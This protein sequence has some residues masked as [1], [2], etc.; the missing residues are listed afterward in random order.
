[1]TK[2]TTPEFGWLSSLP[3]LSARQRREVASAFRRALVES[4]LPVALTS[5][6][7][8]TI[9]GC[10]QQFEEMLGVDEAS[11]H[12]RR[13]EDLVHP[14]DRR[15]TS[16]VIRRLR[17]GRSKLER[18]EAR[19]IRPDGRVVWTR[20]SVLRVDGPAEVGG[21]YLVAVVEDQT[22]L[23]QSQE[24]SSALV[25]IGTRIAA[26]ASLDETVQRLT[27]LAEVRWSRS[28]CLLTVLDPENN[29]LSA[30]CPANGS[31]F[32]SELPALPVGPA[33]G[34]CGTAAWRDEPSAVPNLL[35]DPSVEKLRPIFARNGVV[36]SWAVPLHDAEGHVIGTL[37]V[38]HSYPFSPTEED[39]AAAASVAGVAAIAVIAERRRQSATREQ[40]RVRTDPRTGL[41]NDV[42]LMEHIEAMLAGEHPVSVAVAT[43]RGPGRL[44]SLESMARTAL[45]T[46]AARGRALGQVPEVAATG[47][48]TVA[49]LARAEWGEREARLLH[50]VLTR[51]I[52]VGTAVIRPEV[53]VGIAVSTVTG[54]ETAAELLA[55]ATLAVP[56]R[57]G[58]RLAEPEAPDATSDHGLVTEIT[59]AFR[60][61]EFVPYYQPQFDL[62]TGAAVGSEALA[63][64]QHPVR[65]VLGPSSF[66]S[67]VDS[68]GASTEL[69]FAMLRRVAAEHARRIDL[70][71]AGH[72]AV[73][74][75]A[76]DLLNESLLQVLRD[77]ERQLWRQ[78]SLELTEAQFVRPDA[79]TAVE[80]LAALGYA[81]ALDDF[82]TGYS[83]LSAI[84]T[85]PVSVVKIDQS[86]VAR[87]Q[88]DA[89]AEA[90]IAA[91]TALCEQLAIT[92]VAEG[93]ET[94][95][96]A[97]AVRDLGCRIGQGFLFGSPQPIEALVPEGLSRHDEAARARRHP[98]PLGEAAR[99]RLQELDVQGASPA[100]I[101]AALNRSG[102][103][104][105][106]GTRWHARSVR[107]FLDE[108]RR[109]DRRR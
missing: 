50:R 63:R 53:A 104:A 70:G 36:S 55:R 49:F 62:V 2:A 1:M 52:D 90:L 43:L 7:D 21:A 44:A 98:Q 58:S 32:L 18:Y 81:I 8:G 101:A 73:N 89:S 77:P 57:G 33:G 82:G 3:L 5:V 51:P 64:W 12:G 27:S 59:R 26:G 76:D 72:V 87:L 88:H 69:A 30:I 34:A 92:V 54:A 65:G 86:F 78:V 45:T 11:L 100:T 94:S 24:L 74:V 97:S 17:D 23:R 16:D 37:G 71:L 67:I 20:R 109:R 79:V 25:D 47:V 31:G 22:A 80:E 4:P 102:Y 99:R 10:N 56:A 40:Q 29:V 60:R 9:L 38:F 19:W 42:G 68:I 96:Q 105:P 35:E 85:L 13:V 93:I 41:L 107:S 66:L 95:E 14:E 106:G 15:K 46:L 91:I 61:D 6:G 39:W 48:T 84:H 75:T 103:R 108:Q 83:A 28:G